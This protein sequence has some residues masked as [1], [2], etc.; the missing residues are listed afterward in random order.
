MLLFSCQK[1]INLDTG[2]PSGGGNGSGGS[3][4]GSS[5]GA[6]LIKSVGKTATDSSL[7]VYTYDSQNRMSTMTVDDNSMGSPVC[8]WK[9]FEYDNIGRVSK[10]TQASVIQS[11]PDT[12]INIIHYPSA[13]AMEMDYAVNTNTMNMMG[14][15]MTT[16]DSSVF[17]YIS[18]KLTSVSV[19]MNNSIMG[20]GY[21]LSSKNDFVYDGTGKVT[22][23]KLYGTTTPG[24]P[25]LSMGD[26]QFTY[27]TA[28]N[29]T[30]LPGNVAQKYWIGGMPN[31]TNEA[32]TRMQVVNSPSATNGM[33][34]TSTYT[35]G[36]NNLPATGVTIQSGG[37]QPTRTVNYTFFYR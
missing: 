2:T 12:A 24:S 4:G 37:G 9:K 27:G 35:L 22:T 36:S 21:Y 15:T 23:L 16:M 17:S 8:T 5:S 20:T 33:T 30:W 11:M 32:V 1:E 14:L 10:I 31:A 19:Y 29:P 6:L 26:E 3:G 7:T 25:L 28:F 13:T 34:L 18:G